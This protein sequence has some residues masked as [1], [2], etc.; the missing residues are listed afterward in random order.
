MFVSPD[1]LFK[2]LRSS[3][4]ETITDLHL[5]TINMKSLVAMRACPNLR[6]LTF[7][8]KHADEKST[9]KGSKAFADALSALTN[10][11]YLNVDGSACDKTEPAHT[12]TMPSLESLQ[13]SMKRLP[14]LNAPNLNVDCYDTRSGFCASVLEH[15]PHLELLML[16]AD[17][18]KIDCSAIET[19]IKNGHSWPKLQGLVLECKMTEDD[20]RVLN[21]LKER[22]PVLQ[23]CT[24]FDKL[25]RAPAGVPINCTTCCTRRCSCTATGLA[26]CCSSSC[27]LR[28]ERCCCQ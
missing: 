5:G 19:L 21:A 7:T 27:G 26:P 22:C 18:H 17:K 20:V 23:S 13:T 28:C 3:V 24:E 14:L 16:H 9:H 11:T 12:A 15:S 10:L 4:R 6:A 1:S 25:V 8:Y 2:I